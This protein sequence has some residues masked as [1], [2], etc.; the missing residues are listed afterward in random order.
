[1]TATKQNKDLIK[2]RRLLHKNAELSGQEKK[3]AEIIISVLNKT[4]PDKIL[5]K[6]GGYGVAAVY[7]GAK[8]GWNL[9]FRCDMDA[10]PIPETLII[11]YRSDNN[12]VSHK[13]GHDGHMAIML[14]FAQLLGDKRPE[15][16]SITLL[17][18]PSEE[19]GAGARLVLDDPVFQ[20]K[21][22]Q[23]N[24]VFALHNLPG[25]PLK[26]VVVKQHIFASASEGLIVR[27]IGATSHAAEPHKGI[28]PA[29]AL[30][31]LLQ[32][33]SSIPQ[34]H[35]A[36]HEA[37]QVTVIHV[38]LGEI[39]FGTSPGYG[40]LMAT[41]RSHSQDTMERIKLICEK[42]VV[43]ISRA[44]QLDASIRWQE[45]FPV[46]IN[47]QDV[48]KVIIE[49]AQ[50]LKLSVDCNSTPFPWSEDFGHFTD[51]YKGAMFGLGAGK[52]QPALH[53]PAYDYPDVLIDTGI[54]LFTEIMRQ[55]HKQQTE[56]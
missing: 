30:A 37:G 26:Q 1:M 16:G 10:L 24:Y 50:R 39:A 8:P 46:T 45:G 38:R 53:H 23:P 7:K 55:I 52:K 35:T 17:F 27:L 12:A 20:D 43:S 41:L 3:T 40:E 11:D 6:I 25:F 14:G 4:N 9:L 49:S 2:L 36:L 44:Y 22:P 54:K 34:F 42:Q 5:K 31:Q 13:C 47:N 18:Q 51:K 48:V 15:K 19:T 21:I 29:L 33:L 56:D 32:S 28:N